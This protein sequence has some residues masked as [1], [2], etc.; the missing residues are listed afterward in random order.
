MGKLQFQFFYFKS[1]GI[2]GV[3]NGNSPAIMVFTVNLQGQPVA[4]RFYQFPNIN[5]EN[6]GYLLQTRDIQRSFPRSILA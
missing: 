2:G 3:V 6:L 1:S 4:T 5:V